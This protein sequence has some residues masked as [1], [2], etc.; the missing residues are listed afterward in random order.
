MRQRWKKVLCVFLAAVL[1]FGM[2]ACNAGKKSET[3]A[4]DTG[5]ATP[6][7]DDSTTEVEATSTP[8][9]GEDLSKQDPVT[10]EI[11]AVTFQSTEPASTDSIEKA[12]ND[13]VK[14]LINV[15]V[16]LNIIPYASYAQQL[17]LLLS[18][19][20]QA[21]LIMGTAAIIS[22]YVAAGG[23]LQ[24]DDAVAKYGDGI[25]ESL[26][27]DAINASKISDALYAVP[28]NRDF[29][30]AYGFM[31]NKNLNDKY[32][33]GLEN[34]KDFAGLDAA[35]AKLHAQAPEITCVQCSNAN[36]NFQSWDW[37][38]LG[39]QFGVLMN[40]GADLTVQNLFATEEY[41][42]IV[43]QM[44]DWNLAGY[45]NEDAL[46]NTIPA[47]DLMEQEKALGYF[48]N[49]NPAVTYFS[50]S[51]KTPMGMSILVE[52]FSSSTSY[53]GASWM[54]GRNSVDVNRAIQF[55]NLM[56]ADEMVYNLLTYGVEGQD[57]VFADKENG[58]IDYP[59]GVTAA[60][61]MVDHN[62]WM[63]GNEF[64]GYIWNGDS[65]D[66]WENLKT[67]NNT[68]YKSKA[69]GFNFDASNVQNE[70]AACSNVTSKYRVGLECG[71]V[72][73]EEVLP[74]F[75]DELNRNGIDTI[76]SEKQSQ[77][78]AWAEKNGVK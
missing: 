54:V 42:Q 63:W 41:K 34:V 35:F 43:T 57:Y 36:P 61:S 56:Y 32:G 25:V 65:P 6:G 68:A 31:Y 52:P 59:E 8:G 45:V 30:S 1:V 19:S 26:G 64:I 44:R 51:Y 29:A 75:L 11:Y 24:L 33:L 62:N 17:T 76:V 14:P 3:A 23:V 66:I 70:I 5:A 50:A 73:P 18:G 21:D 38:S 55:L 69:I 40:R 2:T 74:Q 71:A 28:T 58:I 12:I 20:E 39:S 78:D 22:N 13:Y 48:V 37:D 46:T 9:P 53:L 15:S 49:Y 47:N 72:D 16:H 10:L 67:F 4:N 60:T 77:L 27:Q 7:A